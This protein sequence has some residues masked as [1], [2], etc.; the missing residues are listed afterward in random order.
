MRPGGRLVFAA[1]AILPGSL[2][3]LARRLR[4]TAA[5]SPGG[6]A[7]HGLIVCLGQAEPDELSAG[8][9]VSCQGRMVAKTMML[10]GSARWWH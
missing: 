7:A 4:H 9:R 5:L 8:L 2:V 10:T 3:L 1:E 6:V